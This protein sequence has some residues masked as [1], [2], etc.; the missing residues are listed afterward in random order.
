MKVNKVW[1]NY[2]F[3]VVFVSLPLLVYLFTDPK[4]IQLFNHLMSR[5]IDRFSKFIAFLTGNTNE[6]MS[7]MDRVY[8][9]KFTIEKIF[10]KLSSVLFGYGIGSFGIMYKGI[11][12]R[13]YPHNTFLESWFE[14]GFFA[15]IFFV[16]F[17]AIPLIQKRKNPFI[18]DAVIYYLLLNIMKSYTFADMRQTYVFMALFIYPYIKDAVKPRLRISIEP[19]ALDSP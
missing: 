8:M 19:K 7:S 3:F 6:D 4:F 11:D 14:L 1:L 9:W 10:S 2:L 16:L 12:G 15:M 13:A 5:S 18:P 17:F